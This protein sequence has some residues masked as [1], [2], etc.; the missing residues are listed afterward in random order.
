[1]TL[2]HAKKFARTDRKLDTVFLNWLLKNAHCLNVHYPFQREAWPDFRKFKISSGRSK[3][4]LGLNVFP[5][6]PRGN[7]CLKKKKS[8]FF[9]KEDLLFPSSSLSRWWIVHIPR[10]APPS[11]FFLSSSLIICSIFFP[12]PCGLSGGFNT[13]RYLH[14]E[15]AVRSQLISWYAMLKW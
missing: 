15:M 9:L 1:M 6:S 14:G 5:S 11:A 12:Q 2:P 13:T 8:P 10:Q 4:N 3:T 7:Y